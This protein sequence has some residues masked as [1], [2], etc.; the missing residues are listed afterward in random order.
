MSTAQKL[1]Q[2]LENV[3]S[4]DAWYG[5]PVY[6]IIAQVS[7][8]AAYER[9]PNHAHSIAEIVLHMLGW[10]EEVIRRMQGHTAAEPPGGDWPDAGTPDE[11]KWK[12]LVND[13]KLMNV[14]LI[15]VIENFP[16]EKWNTPINDTRNCELGT[17]VSYEAL[18]RGLIQHHIYHSAQISLLNRIVG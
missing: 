7:F 15:G 9:P 18:I 3:L 10:T 1:Q 8:E 14:E 17:G 12:T 2:E 6:N 16:E 11:H 13:L 5:S 4:G